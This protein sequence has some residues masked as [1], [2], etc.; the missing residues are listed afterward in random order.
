VREKKRERRRERDRE[1]R[2]MGRGEGERLAE[3]W[4]LREIERR[5][6]DRGRQTTRILSR[7]V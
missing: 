4:C 3:G 2:G 7:D 5:E 1:G 6:G